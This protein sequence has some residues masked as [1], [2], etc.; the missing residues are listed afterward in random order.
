MLKG[1]KEKVS[2]YFNSIRNQ[3]INKSSIKGF[4]KH[5]K[6]IKSYKKPPKI[7]LGGKTF[8]KKKSIKNKTKKIYTK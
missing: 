6:R 2:K 8:N 1:V 3:N 7:V 4:T 5:I